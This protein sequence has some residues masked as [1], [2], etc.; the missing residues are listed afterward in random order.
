MSF[1]EEKGDG[2][3]KFTLAQMRKYARYTQKE[4][5][6]IIGVTPQTIGNWENCY[7]SLKVWQLVEL[8]NLYQCSVDDVFLS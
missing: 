7:T 1:M 8:C 5:A 2:S 3:M 6:D 4:A